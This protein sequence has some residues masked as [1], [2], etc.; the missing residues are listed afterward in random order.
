MG[1]IVAIAGGD[2]ET[3]QKINRY[4]ISLSKKVHPN[5]LF[6]GTA[7]QD[8]EGYAERFKNAFQNIGCSV[9]TLA[10]VKRNY[11]E[12][13]VEE[14]LFWA[15]IIYVGGGDTV[16]MMKIWKTIS[17]DKKLKEIYRKDH[18]VL[19]GISAGAI[20]WFSGGHSDSESFMEDENWNYKI[21]DGMLGIYPFV[22]CPHYNDEG[23]KSFDKMLKCK[24]MRG[25]AMESETAFVDV[26]GEISF[27]RS[28]ESAKAYWIDWDNDNLHKKEVVFEN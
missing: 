28:R 12:T 25:L 17:F 11:L 21:V 10:L 18:A 24:N 3:T 23:R 16:S 2:L 6:I 4:M 9:K 26:N 27:I 22:F 15:D 20:C 19:G 5:V 8:D 1:R 14:L 7:S 13:D